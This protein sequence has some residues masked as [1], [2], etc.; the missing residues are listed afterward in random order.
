MDRVGPGVGAEVDQLLSQL[1]DAVLDQ[2]RR[3][4][5]VRSR[6]FRARV[7]TRRALGAVAL[8]EGA[9]PGR[10]DPVFLGRR[11]NSQTLG[12]HR[13]HN[14]LVLDHDSPPPRCSL[15]RDRSVHYVMKVETA[16]G[17]KIIVGFKREFEFHYKGVPNSFSTGSTR[18]RARRYTLD[19][20]GFDYPRTFLALEGDVIVELVTAGPTRDDEQRR[21]EICAL[22]VHPSSWRTG[23]GSVQ[24]ARAEERLAEQVLDEVLL[25]D[26]KSNHRARSVDEARGWLGDGQSLT[27]PSTHARSSKFATP[28][29]FVTTPDLTLPVPWHVVGKSLRGR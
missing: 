21:G 23:V 26:L 11:A 2:G 25:R 5:R 13:R 22:D 20:I 19:R 3:R 10:R 14:D 8:D 24:I 29:R 6:S 18:R 9:D 16:G 15:C 12:H 4:R 27:S 17:T 7:K 28:R 1:D